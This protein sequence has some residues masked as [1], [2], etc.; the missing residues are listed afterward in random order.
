MVS[1]LTVNKAITHYTTLSV[2]S[3]RLRA[4]GNFR[5][6]FPQPPVG[7]IH[8]RSLNSQLVV[9]RRPCPI[10]G[11]RRQD[12]R[13]STRTTHWIPRNIK[14][15]LGRPPTRWTDYFRKNI[16]QPGRHW[17]TVAQDRA[18]WRTCGPR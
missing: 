18:A 3:R 12:D 6:A 5:R 8:P 2:A 7:P 10:N 9:E 14:R 17:M 4:L 16:S 13:W 1:I 11:I 15:P